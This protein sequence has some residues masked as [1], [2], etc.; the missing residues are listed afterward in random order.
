M[1]QTEP[2]SPFPV[3]RFPVPDFA[4]GFEALWETKLTHEIK[5]RGTG[6]RG[7]SLILSRLYEGGITS[8][9]PVSRSQ[10]WEFR[11]NDPDLRVKGEA[12]DCLLVGSYKG[13]YAV[14][15]ETGEAARVEKLG[16]RDTFKYSSGSHAVFGSLQPGVAVLDMVSR[17]VVRYPK[18]LEPC[19]GFGDA[20]FAREPGTKSADRY[21]GRN[22]AGTGRLLKSNARLFNWPEAEPK[23]LR[24]QGA[25]GFIV[26]S[27]GD[28][29]TCR[30]WIHSW[31]GDLLRELA[32][33]EPG[34]DCR[35]GMS[36]KLLLAP[37]GSLD[38]LLIVI[39]ELPSARVFLFS[40][41]GQPELLWSSD[42]KGLRF[43][44]PLI[45]GNRL[46]W[47][48]CDYDFSEEHI[49]RFMDLTTGE[50]GVFL[51]EPIGDYLATD[52]RGIFFGK[53][54][55]GSHHLAYGIFTS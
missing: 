33:D 38:R 21:I 31:S 19:I 39:R 29:G 28:Q 26:L 2:A 49:G 24:P 36:V 46:F 43:E 40:L 17:Q 42:G 13:F 37:D 50:S 11:L 27:R 30:M 22:E 35:N 10:T 14:N 15:R 47:T 3:S 52:G 48:D 4:P 44:Q 34:F 32:I 53:G 20:F 5:G 9:D 51:D 54:K 23:E 12:G 16:V 25:T 6:F 41:A 8:F 18:D 55:Q 7:P 45:A 1:G